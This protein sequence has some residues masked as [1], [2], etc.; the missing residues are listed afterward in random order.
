MR[1]LVIHP[2]LKLVGSNATGRAEVYRDPD[3][4]MEE[5]IGFA[6]AIK[7]DVVHNEIIF[8]NHHSDIHSKHPEL[9]VKHFDKNYNSI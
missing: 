3:G 5:A 8:V 2:S 1:C 9:I 7:L 6:Q 4:R